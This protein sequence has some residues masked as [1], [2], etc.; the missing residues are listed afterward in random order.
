MALKLAFLLNQTGYEKCFTH[1]SGWFSV[2]NAANGCWRGWGC[3]KF[4]NWLWWFTDG[5][6]N[7]VKIGFG[8]KFSCSGLW[9]MINVGLWLMFGFKPIILSPLTWKYEV[10]VKGGKAGARVGI[11]WGFMVNIGAVVAVNSGSSNLIGLEGSLVGGSKLRKFGVGVIDWGFMSLGVVGG[12]GVKKVGIPVTEVLEKS[13]GSTC[14]NFSASKFCVVWSGVVVVVNVGIEGVV[15]KEIGSANGSDGVEEIIKVEGWTKM[16]FVAIGLTVGF[17]KSFFNSPDNWGKFWKSVEIFGV[18]G[19]SSVA[20]NVV[21]FDLVLVTGGGREMIGVCVVDGKITM[22][23]EESVKP[24]SGCLEE[25]DGSERT[26][27]EEKWGNLE[28]VKAL[29]P[30]DLCVA[31][32]GNAGRIWFS[33]V[34]SSWFLPFS[35][36]FLSSSSKSWPPVGP[37]LLGLSGGGL[38][39]K[40]R[41]LS[42][43]Q[44]LKFWC[45]V[46]KVAP[47][48]SWNPPRN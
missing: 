18:P 8:D 4:A 5:D 17:F 34:I 35:S 36:P 39:G 26:G 46:N 6:W 7:G 16:P 47:V 20:G 19:S 30:V 44:K 32:G 15:M 45:K 38:K 37:W 23:F 42:S 24:I 2:L 3:W 25:S 11:V 10:W 29:D 33:R 1:L 22:S 13:I 14:C 48:W 27:N 28:A 21:N 41:S 43:K 40:W 9:G 31:T 12:G